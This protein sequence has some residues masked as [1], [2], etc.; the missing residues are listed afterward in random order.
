M[1]D[2]TQA[3]CED[4]DGFHRPVNGGR[5]RAGSPGGAGGHG[6]HLALDLGRVEDFRRGDGCLGGSLGGGLAQAL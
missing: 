3:I 6:I 5:P 2:G 4:F 1:T